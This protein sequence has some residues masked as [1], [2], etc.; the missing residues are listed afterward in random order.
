[1]VLD[2]FVAEPVSERRQDAEREYRDVLAKVPDF[3][4]LALGTRDGGVQNFLHGKRES[5]GGTRGEERPSE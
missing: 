4:I 5:L 2:Q 1:M 3:A